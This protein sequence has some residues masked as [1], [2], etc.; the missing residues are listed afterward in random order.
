MDGSL[1]FQGGRAGG[2][3]ERERE[4]ERYTSNTCCFVSIAH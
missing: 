4:R 1:L 3:V 2:G